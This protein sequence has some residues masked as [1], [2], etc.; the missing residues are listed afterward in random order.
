[1]LFA[2]TEMG[3]YFPLHHISHHHLLDSS[4][5]SLLVA[6]VPHA[7]CH[8]ALKVGD[9]YLKPLALLARPKTTATGLATRVTPSKIPLENSAPELIAEC[10]HYA[11][12]MT[13]LEFSRSIT[14]NWMFYAPFFSAPISFDIFISYVSNDTNH[15]LATRY[16]ARFSEMDGT[17]SASYQIFHFLRIEWGSFFN[18]CF[19]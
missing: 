14:C 2:L 18:Q 3:P 16:C 19:V 10:V 7:R 17:I 5:S 13:S 12:N 9:F 15:G 4:P 6:G 8:S 1:M 11:A